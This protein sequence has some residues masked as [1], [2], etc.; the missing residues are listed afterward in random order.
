MSVPEKMLT[1]AQAANRLGLKPG[2]LKKWRKQNRVAPRWER[3]GD[4]AV[5]YPESGIEEFRKSRTLL[6]NTPQ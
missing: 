3:V 2:T 4:R 1:T 5:R 6:K